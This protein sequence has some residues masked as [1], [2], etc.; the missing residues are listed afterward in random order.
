MRNG[1]KLSR[2]GYS[3]L[4]H[5]NYSHCLQVKASE[6][7]WLVEVK[8]VESINNY[9]ICFLC[10]PRSSGH[11]HSDPIFQA[12]AFRPCSLGRMS[13]GRTIRPYA[14]RS[15]PSVDNFSG[16]TFQAFGVL[17]H[18]FS[19]SKQVFILPRIL[20]LQSRPSM[21]PRILALQSRPFMLPRILALQSRLSILF[22]IP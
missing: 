20:A 17:F 16:P 18:A 3:L 14:I 15:Y 9:E 5:H 11:M 10:K 7:W 8:V 22:G 12:H 13:S 4:V 2:K 1:A 21:L 19:P 6:M